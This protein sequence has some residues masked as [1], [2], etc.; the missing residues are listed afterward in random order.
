[1]DIREVGHAPLSTIVRAGREGEQIT[2]LGHNPLD[3]LVK[4]HDQF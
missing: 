2:R 4:I 1:M 3:L